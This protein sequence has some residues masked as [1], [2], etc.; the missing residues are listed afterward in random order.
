[1]KKA[2]TI[3]DIEL[4]GNEE[5]DLNP[6]SMVSDNNLIEQEDQLMNNNN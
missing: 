3:N 1:M 2:T 5:E 4:L 6:S